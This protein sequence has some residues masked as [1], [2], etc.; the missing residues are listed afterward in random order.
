MYVD[1]VVNALR[2][3]LGVGRSGQDRFGLGGQHLHPGVQ[4]G[5]EDHLY[6]YVTVDMT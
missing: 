1:V 5:P 2:S 3:G 4:A 6:K